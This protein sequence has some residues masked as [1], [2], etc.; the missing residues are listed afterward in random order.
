MP[1]YFRLGVKD[2]SGPGP[3]PQ[4]LPPGICVVGFLNV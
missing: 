2:I 3:G 1:G 4:V